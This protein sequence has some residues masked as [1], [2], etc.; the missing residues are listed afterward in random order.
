MAAYALEGVDE[1]GGH[2][3]VKVLGE[4]LCTHPR[5]TFTPSRIGIVLL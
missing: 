2:D 5:S 4:A 1:G 3:A